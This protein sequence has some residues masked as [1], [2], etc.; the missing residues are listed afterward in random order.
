MDQCGGS[1]RATKVVAVTTRSQRRQEELSECERLACERESG[2]MSKSLMEEEMP[3]SELDEKLFT[4]S[5]SRLR[6]S[7]RQKQENDLKRA[8]GASE[9]PGHPLE[10]SCEDLVELQKS[11]ETLE[12][13][14]RQIQENPDGSKGRFLL[15]D[16][17]MYRRWVPVGGLEGGGTVVLPQ[18]CPRAVLELAHSIPL[19]EHL[20]KKTAQRLLQR[21]Y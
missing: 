18:E 4:E 9:D 12:Q 17:V 13:V 14:R 7:H 10:V 5:R 16:G 11:D 1:T 20:G 15:R 19:A 21:F 6:L 8:P 3:L 2:A